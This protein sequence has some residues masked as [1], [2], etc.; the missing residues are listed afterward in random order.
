M[1]ATAPNVSAVPHVQFVECK[2]PA[3]LMYLALR[4]VDAT[5]G[6]STLTSLPLCTD[7][8]SDTP[9]S[10]HTQR[11][12]DLLLWMQRMAGATLTCRVSTESAS[13]AG[14]AHA[15]DDICILTG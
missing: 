5:M 4:P 2:H 6:G 12:A 3:A 10:A 15:H 11:M 14:T 8:A 13:A 9:A 1:Y 7:N